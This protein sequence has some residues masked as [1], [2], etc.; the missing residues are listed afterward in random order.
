MKHRIGILVVIL[1]ALLC[2][3]A[4]AA[5][6][7]LP[8]GR[9][10]AGQ[11]TFE[12]DGEGEL[13]LIGENGYAARLPDVG[14]VGREKG[15]PFYNEITATAQGAGVRVKA[16]YH[17]ADMEAREDHA[18]VT[19]Y[20]TSS[21]DW[22]LANQAETYWD[23]ELFRTD[24]GA[25]VMRQVRVG[26]TGTELQWAWMQEYST[27]PWHTIP[28]P[29]WNQG[30]WWSFETKLLPYNGKTFMVQDGI[31]LELYASWDGQSWASLE[32]TYLAAEHPAGM[33]RGVS[34]YSSDHRMLW[35][36]R[37]YMACRRSLETGAPG[38]MFAGSGTWYSPYT[39]KVV[40]ADASWKVTGEYDFG[41]RVVG[42]SYANGVYY[43]EV[44]ESQ[45]VSF[46]EFDSEAGTVIWKSADKTHWEK[47]DLAQVFGALT[48]V[49]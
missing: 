47:T 28:S 29:G 38:V 15:V 33:S 1:A 2:S 46:H 18:Y 22:V 5:G 32:D 42:V 36:G 48:R 10:V 20:P 16:V 44:S 49:A 11:Y 34:V 19:V 27:G 12:L 31:S 43:A 26:P 23:P 4:L 41:R 8:Q 35:T 37:E 40:F 9:A 3:S 45:T 30:Y 14:K 25:M 6:G 21:L 39:T 24:N 13:W 7:E 17:P